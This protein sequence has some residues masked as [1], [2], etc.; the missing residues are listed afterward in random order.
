MDSPR[1]FILAKSTVTPKSKASL[2]YTG[3]DFSW[4]K[5]DA[6]LWTEKTT[7]KH[8]NDDVIQQLIEFGMVG[9]VRIIRNF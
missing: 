1:Y 3:K 4:Y 9:R 2:Y 7:Q 5:A 8:L 6:R